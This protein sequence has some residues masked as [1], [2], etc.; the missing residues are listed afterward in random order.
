MNKIS[1]RALWSPWKEGTIR[2]K[3]KKQDSS[4]ATNSAHGIV[5]HCNIDIN[6]INSLSSYKYCWLLDIAETSQMNFRKDCFQELNYIE[7]GIVYFAEKSILKPREICSVKLKLPGFLD[8][9]LNNVCYL[10]NL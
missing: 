5:S 8:F 2:I 7:K 10:T 1:F 9:L 3:K 4:K 6:E